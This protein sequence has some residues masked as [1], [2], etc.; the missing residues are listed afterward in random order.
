MVLI[1]HCVEESNVDTGTMVVKD[2]LRIRHVTVR[3]GRIESMSGLIDP[4]S[5]LN[6]DFPD[7]RVTTCVIAEKF[8]TGAQVAIDDNGMIFATIDRSAYQHYGPV[9]YTQRL[10]EMI[11]AVRANMAEAN[12]G[13]QEKKKEEKEL[14][15]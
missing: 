11:R 14:P 5:H 13:E 6:L 10:M 7:H 8:E 9:D 12:T 4:A 15:V 1:R 3:A 2:P